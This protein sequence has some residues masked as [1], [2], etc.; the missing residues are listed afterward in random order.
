MNLGMRGSLSEIEKKPAHIYQQ[1]HKETSWQEE[2]DQGVES[3]GAG[4]RGEG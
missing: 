1:Q 3:E 4:G 2:E